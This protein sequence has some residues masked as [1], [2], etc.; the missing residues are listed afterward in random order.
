VIIISIKDNTSIT[1]IE[2]IIR[3]KV[4]E[5]KKEEI[6][7]VYEDLVM[8]IW[9]RLVPTLG[10]FTVK[11]VMKRS[12][13]MSREN[14]ELLSF[15]EV[16]EG[17]CFTCLTDHLKNNDYEDTKEALKEFITNLIDI[18]ATLTGNVIVTEIIQEIGG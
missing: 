16:K 17:I 10:N 15:L 1:L 4:A 7:K 5:V 13:N 9:N 18:L 6:L 3:E 14:Y 8:N 11:A 2:D 12:L